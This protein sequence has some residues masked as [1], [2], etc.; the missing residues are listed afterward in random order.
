MELPRSTVFLEIEL[1]EEGEISVLREPGKFKLCR[2]FPNEEIIE[3]LL[4]QRKI[5]ALHLKLDFRPRIGRIRQI[6]ADRSAPVCFIC[7]EMYL[8]YRLNDFPYD[9]DKGNCYNPF[10]YFKLSGTCSIT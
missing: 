5:I 8:D 3:L 7:G 4:R 2:T 6:Q 9:P 10:K 1:F